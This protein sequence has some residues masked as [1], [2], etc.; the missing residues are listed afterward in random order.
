LSSAAEGLT[1]ALTVRMP[2]SGVTQ[3]QAYEARVLPL[4]A[5]HGGKLERRLRN[6]DGT[7]EVHIVHFASRA[8]FDSFRNDPM[9]SAAAH[10]LVASGAVTEL[11][12]VN[13]V[14]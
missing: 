1:L 14:D 2:A 7:V 9:R 12:E 3:F 11:T 5:G 8:E 4:L 10:L 13:D 6:A